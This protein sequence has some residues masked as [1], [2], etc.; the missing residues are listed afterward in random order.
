MK[1]F[2]HFSYLQLQAQPW[3]ILQEDYFSFIYVQKMWNVLFGLVGPISF[4]SEEFLNQYQ[5]IKKCST[6]P[7]RKRPFSFQITSSGGGL[8]P[9][10]QLQLES[11]RVWSEQEMKELISTPFT[12]FK[13]NDGMWACW[14]FSLGRK[15][16]SVA[17]WKEKDLLNC[18]P[19][20]V[21]ENTQM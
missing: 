20:H 9:S 21:V 17:W 14:G 11:R 19:A 5:S 12:I 6:K 10:S 1:I 8:R 4:Q 7:S 16:Q 2:Y 15:Y 3:L 13:L 18:V